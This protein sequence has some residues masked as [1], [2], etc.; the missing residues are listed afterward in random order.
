VFNRVAKWSRRSLGGILLFALGCST[1]PPKSELPAALN[2]PKNQRRLPAPVVPA[3]VPEPENYLNVVAGG[4]VMIGHWTL[5]YLR[6]QG[7][8]YPFRRIAPLLQSGDIVFAN[9]EAPLADSGDVAEKRFTFKVPTQHVSGL[10]EAGFNLLSLANNHMLDFGAL[11]LEQTLETLDRAGIL[12]AG[13]GRDRDAAWQPAVFKTPAGTVAAL[14]FS[15]TFPKEFWATDSSAGTAYPL[16][17]RLIRTLETLDQQVDFLIVS[18]HWGTEKKDTPNDY[19]VYFA[20]LAIDH[21][22]D[23]V[24][25]HHP[26]VLQ[27]LEIYK[28]RL[29]AYSLGNLAFSSFS[30]AAVN[31]MLLKVVLHRNGLLFAR[32]YPLNVDN[33]EVLFQPRLAGPERSRSIF[34]HLDT[35][36]YALN[37]YDIISDEGMIVGNVAPLALRSPRVIGFNESHSP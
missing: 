18:F 36:S 24:L 16:E 33:G 29:I 2:L 23:L 3:Q 19:Q 20:H 13:A 10:Q 34:A 25:G 8:D 1:A 26:H 32:I 7:S 31:S 22:A 17:G 11:G 37:G 9:L 30:Y 21:G 28:N 35:L 15:M 27:G 4:D 14:A 6:N 12:H 5:D